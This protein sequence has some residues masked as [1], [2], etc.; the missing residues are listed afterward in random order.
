[1][2][3]LSSVLSSDFQVLKLDT[4]T[5]INASIVWESYSPHAMAWA[6]IRCV[7]RAGIGSSAELMQGR[8]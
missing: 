3:D 2:A 7:N 8:R 6:H 1:M 5:K 4:S